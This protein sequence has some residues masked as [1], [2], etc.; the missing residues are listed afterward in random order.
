[1]EVLE[2]K[3]W[4]YLDKTNFGLL[5]KLLL[6]NLLK[7]S[8]E[9]F[10]K[11]E[12]TEVLIEFC[13]LEKRDALKVSLSNHIPFEKIKEEWDK[14]G[15]GIKFHHFYKLADKLILKENGL[16]SLSLYFYL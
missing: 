14:R 10:E 5:K 16:T 2:K 15:R 6:V 7:T 9:N 3:L 8:L 13:H 1:M 11:F 4:E 12:K